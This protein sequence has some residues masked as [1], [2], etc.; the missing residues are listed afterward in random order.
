MAQPQAAR[1]DGAIRPFRVDVAEVELDDLRR[2]IN[3]TKWPEQETV[4][5]ESQGVRLATI[6]DLARYWGKD[7]DWRKCEAKL[8]ALPQ[9]I[10]EIDGLKRARGDRQFGKVHDFRRGPSSVRASLSVCGRSSSAA[11]APA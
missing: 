5:D 4:K 10:T 11:E 7:Y 8:N 9:F 1:R 2:R 6:Q 3:A